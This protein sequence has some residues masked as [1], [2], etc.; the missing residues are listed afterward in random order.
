MRLPATMYILHACLPC[1]AAC[2]CT[3]PALLTPVR[4]PPT[5]TPPPHH[6]PN[7]TCLPA[8]RHY[9]CLQLLLPTCAA[10]F[11]VYTCSAC[12]HGRVHLRAPVSHHALRHAPTPVHTSRRVTRVMA[13]TTFYYTVC[14]SPLLVWLPATPPPPSFT[15]RTPPH[16]STRSATSRP[17]YLHHILSPW[18]HYCI[19]F[20]VVG[21][22]RHA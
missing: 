3:Q 21:V 4:L 8:T 12:A 17:T 22:H 18:R 11:A 16:C 20:S 2:A 9:T 10:W 5:Y 6:P 14:S 1:P 15:G 7:T 19:Q 13:W